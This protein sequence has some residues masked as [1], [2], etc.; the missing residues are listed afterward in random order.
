[1]DV[2]ADFGLSWAALL[3]TSSYK[4]IYVETCHFNK[5]FCSYKIAV[6]NKLYPKFKIDVEKVQIYDLKEEKQEKIW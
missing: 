1:M 3:I 5:C 2:Q 6:V 4:N